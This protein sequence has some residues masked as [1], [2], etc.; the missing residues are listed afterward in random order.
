[1]RR[2]TKQAE[3]VLQEILDHRFENGNCD[4][5]Y[6]K[7][8][9]EELSASEDVILRSLFRELRENDMISVNWGDNYPYKL[10]VLAKG[11]SYFEEINRDDNINGSSYVNNF[12][13]STSNVQIQQGNVNSFQA[14]ND[15]IDGELYRQLID[16]IKKYDAVLDSEFK[17]QANQM[18]ENISELDKAL[19]EKN[20]TRKRKIVE[21]IRDIATNATGGLIAAGV[22]ELATR[23]MG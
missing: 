15:K 20:E 5:N 6:W 1:M 16:T 4:T 8:R 10:F 9:F 7:N 21:A 14:M 13:G 2:I 18:R 22:I 3:N 11:A 23:I 12:F 19:T 17:D